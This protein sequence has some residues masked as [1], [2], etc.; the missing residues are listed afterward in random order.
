MGGLKMI[1]EDS[2]K[3]NHKYTFKKS[4]NFQEK[5]F[6]RYYGLLVQDSFEIGSAYSLHL[7][8]GDA[9]KFRPNSW[10]DKSIQREDIG[11][12]YVSL[13]TLEDLTKD[14]EKVIFAYH[15]K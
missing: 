15:E 12:V 8:K 9:E 4:E 7:T 14:E 11:E 2:W 1:N 6:I 3:P 13:R 5:V 10:E